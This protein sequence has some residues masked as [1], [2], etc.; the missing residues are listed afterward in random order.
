LRTYKFLYFVI[1]F[2]ARDI[3][4]VRAISGRLFL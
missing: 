3:Q 4:P 2:A 1:F